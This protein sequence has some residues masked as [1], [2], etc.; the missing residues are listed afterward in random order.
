M[1]HT[2]T[3]NFK[4]RFSIAHPELHM[5]NAPN[6]FYLLIKQTP[7]ETLA[8][9]EDIYFGKYFYFESNGTKKKYGNCMGVEA[10]DAQVD[11]LFKIQEE[12]GVQISLTL[13]TL[14]V[15]EELQTNPEIGNQFLDWIGAF[16]DR[17]LRSCTIAW[18]HLLRS[19]ALQHRCPEMRW[20]NTVNHIVS[21]TQQVVEFISLGYDTILLDRSYNRNIP[22]LKKTKKI[23]DK[24]N[25]IKKELDPNAKQLKTSLLV[26]EGCLYRCPFKKEHDDIGSS[27]SVNYFRTLA[28]FTCNNWRNPIFGQLPRNGVN[29]EANHR[30]TQ[31]QYFENVDILKY[32]GRL[33]SF[34]T[35]SE[36]DIIDKNIHLAWT[37][38]AA[39]VSATK[40]FGLTGEKDY[41]IIDKTFENIYNL[42]AAPMSTWKLNRV[43]DDH[44]YRY[45]TPD[46][47]T[48]IKEKYLYN[49]IWMTE[50]GIRLEKILSV[51]KSQ[52]YQCHECER[53]FDIED[54][55]SALIYG[56]QN[57]LIL[58]K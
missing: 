26:T 46:I 47:Y 42:E 54:I 18:T 44:E 14:E 48:E 1:E 24:Y 49:N 58:K 40:K 56:S 33:D 19:G 12:T 13:N 39:A 15:P 22:E 30:E 43:T 9:I 8:E 2:Q 28:N 38:G 17:G 20:K 52:C 50:K 32:S 6:H 21:D 11:N 57:P 55:D 10:T 29:I 37:F 27:I 36:Q 31:D 4:K 34:S 7:K 41:I 35:F 25:T 23:I 53:T 51:C 45:L 3:Q 16:Y 5:E